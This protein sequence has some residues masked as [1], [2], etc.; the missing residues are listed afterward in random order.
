MEYTD[1]SLIMLDLIQRPAFTVKE[2]IINQ[3]N[4]SAKQLLIPCGDP[5]FPLLLSGTEAYKTFSGGCL[6][7]TINISSLPYAASVN[8]VGDVDV[9]IL[10]QPDAQAELQG[11]ALAATYLRGP[12]N[13]IMTAS[14]S[15][16]PSKVLKE[17][18]EI[19]QHV[20]QLNLGLHQILRNVSNMADAARLIEN[21]A[22]R[23]ECVDIS[24]VLQETFEKASTLLEYA[25]IT[26]TFSGLSKPL[27]CNVNSE[28]LERAVYNILSNAAKYT[29]AGGTI[30]AA[31]VRHGAM[32]HL[33]LEDSG[34]GIEQQMQETAFHRYMRQPSLEDGRAG[35]GLGMTLI[36]AAAA[37]H[38][39]TVLLEQVEAGGLRITLTLAIHQGGDTVRSPMLKVDYAG[40]RDHALIELSD[41]LP[42]N[43]YQ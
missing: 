31:L 15:L 26:L 42:I 39:G 18:P 32:L 22:P 5:I 11:L 43:I 28:M 20:A 6:Y 36:R 19:R 25:K 9:F 2:G 27:Y 23:M 3:V 29:P 37:A 34:S 33:T 24:S 4:H 38:G 13:E 7:L 40:E 21:S 30:Q 41:I 10:E 8:R 16:F 35:L 17:N 14:D 12:L 1:N